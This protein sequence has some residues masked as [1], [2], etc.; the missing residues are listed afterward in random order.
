MSK[1]CV[2]YTV[3]YVAFSGFYSVWV[4]GLKFMFMAWRVVSC[5]TFSMSLSLIVAVCGLVVVFLHPRQKWVIE[6]VGERVHRRVCVLA[7]QLLIHTSQLC[8]E[9]ARGRPDT[10]CQGQRWLEMSCRIRVRPLDSEPLLTASSSAPGGPSFLKGKLAVFCRSL[11]TCS[12]KKM[13]RN[14]K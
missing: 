12:R 8:P 9:Q 7:C 11:E 10:R 13:T 14:L 4:A 6:R 1:P 2:Y 3:F 5:H